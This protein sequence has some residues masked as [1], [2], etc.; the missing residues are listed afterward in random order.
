[1]YINDLEDIDPDMAK[2][3]IHILNNSVD[4]LSLDFT[5]TYNLLGEE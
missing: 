1:M 5:Y 4:G 2:G 3:L